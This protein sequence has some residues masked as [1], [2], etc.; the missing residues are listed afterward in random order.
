MADGLARTT[1]ADLGGLLR[2]LGGLRAEEVA[3]IRALPPPRRRWRPGAN[4][5]FEPH[6]QIV[7]SGWASRQRVLRDGRRLI[8][9]FVVPGDLFGG[10]EVDGPAREKIVAVTPLEAVDVETLVALAAEADS[11]GEPGGGLTDSLAAMRREDH[12]RLL[13]HMMRLGRLTAIEKVAHFLLEMER[14]VGGPETANG[15]GFRLPLTQEAIGDA[16]G[17]SIVHVNRVLRQLRAEKL[18]A[19]RSGLAWV[20]DPEKLAA[21]AMLEPL[22]GA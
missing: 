7:L 1:A 8:L 11:G 2:R 9:D 12:A 19:L 22:V 13:D 3:R 16:L 20:L 14:R 10:A 15:R 6:P 21:L 18:I 5:S 17:L 4:L